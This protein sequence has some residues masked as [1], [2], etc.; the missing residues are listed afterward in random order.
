MQVSIGVK[1]ANLRR[2][3]SSDD[4]LSYPRNVDT[5]SQTCTPPN[6]PA[7]YVYVYVH[8]YVHVHACTLPTPPAVKNRDIQG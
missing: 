8:V 5:E 3:G 4:D 7:V 1:P 6:A 2:Y